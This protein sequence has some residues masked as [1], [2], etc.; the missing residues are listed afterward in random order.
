MSRSFPS[1]L[2]ATYATEKLHDL[3]V[4]W[5]GQMGVILRR[6]WPMQFPGIPVELAFGFTSNGGVNSNTAT[7]A[8]HADFSELG[9]FGI[10]GGRYDLTAP[11]R[12]TTESN[13]WFRLHDDARVRAMLGR[14]ACMSANCWRA[15]HGGLAD[16]LAIGVVSL[17]DH[18]RSIN[19]RMD[20]L[21]ISHPPSLWSIAMCFWSWSAGPAGAGSFLTRH[22]AELKGPVAGRFYAM[23]EAALAYANEHGPGAAN[24]HGNEAH[25]YIRTSQKLRAAMALRRRNGRG[26]E[27]WLAGL[28]GDGERAALVEAALAVYATGRRPARLPPAPALGGYAGPLAVAG[29]VGTAVTAAAVIALRA[30]R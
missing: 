24:S 20:A 23:G 12:D 26:L 13:D 10:T 29:S 25:G 9:A 18:A 28:K 4:D 2:P 22:A 11:N 8:T 3:S 27:F 7:A 15:D 1:N 21:G 16:Q 17:A 19:R 30:P 6:F 14:N 5:D